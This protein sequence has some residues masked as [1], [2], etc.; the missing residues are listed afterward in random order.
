ML[1]PELFQT[2][3]KGM[4]IHKIRYSLLQLEPWLKNK[5]YDF[6]K[7]QYSEAI[8]LILNI[9]DDRHEHVKRIIKDAL[10]RTSPNEP[11]PGRDLNFGDMASY[12]LRRETLSQAITRLNSVFFDA[13]TLSRYFRTWNW[14]SPSF[15]VMY[16]GAH[17]L[18]TFHKFFTEWLSI[19]PEEYDGTKFGL[20]PSTADFSAPQCITNE[21]YEEIFMTTLF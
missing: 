18:R 9:Y 14:N 11:V 15:A 8:E 1:S 3:K 13:Y 21:N 5:L 10:G 6:A 19:N 20:Y 17:H 2:F 12:P 4:K 7:R 16:V